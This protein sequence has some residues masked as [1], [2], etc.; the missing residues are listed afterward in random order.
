MTEK[1]RAMAAV[2]CLRL[3]A[4]VVLVALLGSACGNDDDTTAEAPA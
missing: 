2:V 4:A 3:L 1:G